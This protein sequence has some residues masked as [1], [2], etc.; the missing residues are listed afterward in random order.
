[1]SIPTPRRLYWNQ[2]HAVH[3]FVEHSLSVFLLKVETTTLISIY[4]LKT[5]SNVKNSSYNSN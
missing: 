3:L 1:M 2:A 5:N 4:K